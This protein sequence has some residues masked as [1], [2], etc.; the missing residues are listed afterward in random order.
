MANYQYTFV[1]EQ[2]SKSWPGGKELFSN[3]NLSFLTNG[4]L[5]EIQ[6]FQ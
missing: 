1:I 2:L 4:P 5:S 3:I 6:P